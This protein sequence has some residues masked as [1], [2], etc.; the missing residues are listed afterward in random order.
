MRSAKCSWWL[1]SKCH[2]FV[3]V[4]LALACRSY[5]QTS[6]GDPPISLVPPIPTVT[7][8]VT[9][10]D[11]TWGGSP[12][13]FTVFRSGNPLPA[14]NV[15]YQVSGTASNGV[16]Y[17][18]LGNW[19]QIPSGVLSGDIVVAPINNGQTGTK[20][21][22]LT[23]T[24]S[25]LMSPMN[26]VNYG[27]GSPSSATLN[28]SPGPATN[29][30][31]FVSLLNPTNG[32]AFW[33]PVDILLMACAYSPDGVVTNVEFFAN[34]VSL[35]SATNPITVLP[36]L[37]LPMPPLPPMPPYRPYELLWTNVLPGTNILLTAKAT[38]NRG[39]ST[40]S[41][42]I[43]IT[44]HPGPAPTPPPPPTNPPPVVR[45]TSPANGSTFRAPINLPLC[46]YAAVLN[47]S[48]TGVEFFAGTNDLG[49]GQQPP[50]AM[51]ML[52][53]GSPLSPVPQDNWT[54]I[55]SNA[56]QGSF[57]IT[58][59]ATDSSGASTVSTTVNVTILPPISPVPTNVVNIDAI[60][61]IAIEGTN[62]WPWLGVTGA[63]PTWSNWVASTAVWQ[64]FTNCGPKNAVLAVHRFGETNADLTVTYSIGGTATNGIDYVTL[65]GS[66]TIPAGQRT[67]LVLIVPIDDGPPDK[68]ST[69]VLTLTPSADYLIGR[70][71]SAAALILD[72][73]IVRPAALPD[74][75]FHVSATGPDGA[76]FH[77][78][79]TS[80]LHAWT[81]LCT[82]QVIHGSIDFL[83]P[84]AP[85][86][87]VRLYRAVPEPDA[88][89]E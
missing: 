59:V 26:P 77:I 4:A 47:G 57:A 29:L 61:P 30:P 46:A 36:A 1:S 32:S 65:P 63:T 16:D 66:V 33:T 17:Q 51:P 84:D 53:V 58:A 75:T 31:P 5:A 85:N 24:N 83:D 2:L 18:P 80:D 45:I 74:K 52:P 48:V 23:L 89:P 12:G 81:A 11:A 54:L 28:I 55:W 69:V 42:S 73:P 44:V 41:G 13:V 35:G 56:P 37:V 60:D 14:L 49:P 64:F 19:V 76:W 72:A 3:S 15:Y 78:E 62:C 22:T 8:S 43:S 71:A 88:G 10:P 25:P 9:D 50:V 67:A 38:D 20:S 21:V 27:I 39:I 68:T 6:T 7:I 70:P 87:P 82:N 40:T 34:G 86:N 79:Y